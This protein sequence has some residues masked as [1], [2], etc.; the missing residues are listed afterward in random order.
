VIALLKVCFSSLFRCLLLFV[1]EPFRFLVSWFR[2][3]LCFVVASSPS[4]LFLQFRIRI[5]NQ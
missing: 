1:R 4:S 2:T 5:F 3:L